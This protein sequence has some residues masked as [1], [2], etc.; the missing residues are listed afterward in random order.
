MYP[1]SYPYYYLRRAQDPWIS[2]TRHPWPRLRHPLRKCP[3][4]SD[5]S[6]QRPPWSRRSA[7]EA[8]RNR[9]GC[10]RWEPAVREIWFSRHWW[11]H[12]SGKLWKYVYFSAAHHK[13]FSIKVDESVLPCLDQWAHRIGTAEDL[14]LACRIIR[15]WLFNCVIIDNYTWKRCPNEMAAVPSL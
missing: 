10:P 6:G 3:G 13:N 7:S 4:A 1:H 2:F 5:A 14:K 12:F 8:P 11:L 15:I 9:E